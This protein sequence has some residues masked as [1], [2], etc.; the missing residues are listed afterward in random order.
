MIRVEAGI[1]TAA[2]C[3]LLAGG[4]A[5]VS[6]L[7]AASACR[8]AR[9]RAVADSVSRP[10]RSGCCRL[11]RSVAAVGLP[12]DRDADADRRR[13]RTR[14]DGVSGVEARRQGARG[15]LPGR[16][17]PARRGQASSVRGA[18]DGA[19]PGLAMRLHRVRDADG[20]HLADR[21]DRRLL[22]ED[23]ARLARRPDPEPPRRDRDR[24]ARPAGER[25]AARPHPPRPRHQPR[26][27]R[28]PAGRARHRQRPLLQVKPLR[29]VR[30]PPPRTDPHP[31]PTQDPGPKRRP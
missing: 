17:P 15:Q 12:D 25:A 19:E 27:R 5:V 10:A 14:F 6:A 3:R 8:H 1:S 24:R 16:T 18:T 29:R 11:R 23:R 22:V 26:H 31:N 9:E 20:R 30:R 2:F 28:D 21:R 13:L 7:A 4:G